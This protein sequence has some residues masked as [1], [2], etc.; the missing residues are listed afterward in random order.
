MAQAC[1]RLPGLQRSLL[2]RTRASQLSSHPTR[3]PLYCTSLYAL[4]RVAA[5]LVATHPSQPPGN[6][7]LK[8]RAIA[9]FLGGAVVPRQLLL[10]DD[11]AQPTTAPACLLNLL[12]G[13]SSAALVACLTGMC[14]CTPCR[15]PMPQHL[16]RKGN[17]CNGIKADSL[18]LVYL[19]DAVREVVII[20]HAGISRTRQ[21]SKQGLCRVFAPK[22]L[23]ASLQRQHLP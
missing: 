3:Q 10:L 23:S 5:I 16:S 15:S 19:S 1:M 7:T 2:R 6:P 13:H 20:T 8:C 12:P 21:D 17:A 18:L 4:A 9:S 11:A 14:A 22:R